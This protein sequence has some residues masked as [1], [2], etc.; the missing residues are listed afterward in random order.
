MFVQVIN[1]C[2]GLGALA[3]GRI[4]CEQP[5]QSGCESDVLVG[6]TLLDIMQNVGAWRMLGGCS[7][8]CHLKM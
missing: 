7:T 8:R 2:A 1:T 4:V 5:I 6:S 3:E